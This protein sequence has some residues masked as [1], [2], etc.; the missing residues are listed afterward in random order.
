MATKKVTDLVELT[1]PAV[2]DLFMIVDISEAL[3]VDKNKKI[4]ITNIGNL[5]PELANLINVGFASIHD[6]GNSGAAKT[7]DWATNGNLQKVTLTGD[8]TFTF[9]APDKPGH[10]TLIML[11]DGTPR[12]LTWPATVIWVG[13]VGEPTWN[14][15]NGNKNIG[16]FLYD[17][18]GDYIAS[19]G[20][21]NN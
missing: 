19:G 20:E 8:C 1:T 14:G 7:I 13:L 3:D 17:D 6:N 9:T 16:S 12:T 15:D 4:A 10:Q 5:I 11:G 21:D 18:D 2:G